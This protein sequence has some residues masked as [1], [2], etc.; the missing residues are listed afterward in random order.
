M[1]GAIFYSKYV[2]LSTG[3]TSL[4]EGGVSPSSIFLG[5]TRLLVQLVLPSNFQLT[6]SSLNF[7]KVSLFAV[8][9]LRAQSRDLSIDSE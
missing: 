9:V 7:C 6:A 2:L 8:S 4:E 5:C 1:K 3:E